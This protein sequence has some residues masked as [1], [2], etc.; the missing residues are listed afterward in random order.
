MNKTIFCA[1]WVRKLTGKPVALTTADCE[2]EAR[3][4]YLPNHAT[5][6]SP[7]AAESKA[8]RIHPDSPCQE[9]TLLAL[10]A[11]K[12]TFPKSLYVYTRERVLGKQRFKASITSKALR[13]T[14]TLR[15]EPGNWQTP[16]VQRL[17]L[18]LKVLLRGF[19]LRAVR[20]SPISGHDS[21]P[22]RKDHSTIHETKAD[23]QP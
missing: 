21:R 17:R 22:A 10:L 11:F 1:L 18:A 2:S 9:T 16:P 7:C 6:V 23:A 13:F 8:F 12:W 15:P 19:G 20:C 14:P 3:S 5:G 4:I